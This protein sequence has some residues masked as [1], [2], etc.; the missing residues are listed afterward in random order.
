[1][2]T[3]PRPRTWSR[4]GVLAA[5]G[6]GALS[7]LTGCAGFRLRQDDGNRPDDELLLNVWAGPAEEEAFRSLADGFARSEG[8]SV[9]VQV[10]PFSEALTAVDTGLRTDAPPDVFRVTYN[11]VGVYR[12]Q[13]VLADLPDPGRLEADFLPPF[14]RAVTDDGGTFGVPHH[15]D[16]TMVLANLAALEAA[17]VGSLP[18]EAEDAWTWEELV[19]VAMRLRDVA[20]SGAFPFAVNWQQ[21]GAYRWLNWLDQA[22]GR[23]LAD[24]LDAVTRADDP[25]LLEAIGTTRS[26]FTDGLV[27]ASSSTKS[28][29]YADQFFTTETVAMGFVGSF[30][31]A[32]VEEVGFEWEAT[33][34]PQRERAS[35]DLGGNALVAVDGPRQE[36]ALRFLEYC[37]GQQQQADFC[38][39]TNVIPTRA[40]LPPGSLTYPIAPEAMAR[41]EIQAQSIQEELVEQVTIPAFSAVNA[42]LVD[43][44]E[45]AFIGD[46]S[47]SDAGAARRLLDQ[48][49]GELSR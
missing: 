7:T 12:S 14:W 11:D 41:F 26:F 5:A 3:A 2:S 34:L 43:G 38:S 19:D 17:G 21:A 42:A 1:M 28:A 16:T 33:W 35:A 49:A 18:A 31:L 29:Q 40:D 32:T 37:A 24:D 48:V 13:G 30:S 36:Q 39:L 9:T 22:G 44:L 10:V 45:Q 47:E 15:T 8:G 4:R 20:A 6:A 23:L 27:P 46:A 25:A